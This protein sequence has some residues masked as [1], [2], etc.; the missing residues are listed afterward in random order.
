MN[1]IGI[2]IAVAIAALA[3]TA[4]KPPKAQRVHVPVEKT[5]RKS[6]S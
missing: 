4:K 2:A 5:T 6:N 3:L 1:T